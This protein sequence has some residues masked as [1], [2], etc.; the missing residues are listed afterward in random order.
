MVRIVVVDDDLQAVNTIKELIKLYCP[1]G[2]LVDYATDVSKALQLLEGATF[3]LLLL[4][5]NLGNTTGFDLLDQL[6]TYKFGLAFT[7]AYDQ[8]A[9]KAFQYYAI[10][11]LLKP[12]DPDELS[13]LIARVEKKEE[14]S[15]SA[16]QIKALS[17]SIQQK[18]LNRLLLSTSEGFF[19]LDLEQIVRLEAFKSYT[20]FYLSNNKKITVAKTIKEYERLLPDHQFFRAHQS[21][22]INIKYIY[23]ISKKDGGYIVTHDGQEVPLARRKKV[24][25]LQ[26]LAGNNLFL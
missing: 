19:F 24:S 8:F 18:K 20:T 17:E 26:L 13:S 22:M 12:I 11:Y 4:D 6:E 5:I 23:Q 9:L 2:Q 21:H 14:E 1:N 25:L 7:T 10:D 16:E 15:F 3:D